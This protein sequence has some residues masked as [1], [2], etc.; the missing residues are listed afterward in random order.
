M[1]APASVASCSSDQQAAAAAARRGNINNNT[2]VF[3]T[4]QWRIQE[5]VLWDAVDASP[6]LG[7]QNVLKAFETA[8]RHNRRPTE[9]N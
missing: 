8:I 7:G 5:I 6:D 1:V 2:A 3:S 4:L 9:R